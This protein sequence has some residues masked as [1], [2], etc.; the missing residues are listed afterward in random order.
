MLDKQEM[1][2]IVNMICEKQTS[3]IK[4]HKYDSEEYIKLEQIKVKLRDAL[5]EIRMSTSINPFT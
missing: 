1:E 4:K 3:L 2:I 5:T